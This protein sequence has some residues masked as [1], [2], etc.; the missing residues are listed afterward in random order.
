MLFMRKALVKTI[1]ILLCTNLSITPLLANSIYTFDQN[2]IMNSQ[3]QTN[4]V[5]EEIIQL[6]NEIF[7][8]IK[9]KDS[10]R[11]SKILTDDF[12]YRS[13]GNAEQKKAEFLKTVESI[14][15]T[16]LAIWSDDM[17]LNIY[18]DVA[19]MTGTQKAKVLLAKDKEVIVAT[20]FTD[21]FI[22]RQER[23]LLVLAHGVEL[24]SSSIDK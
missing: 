8:A 24:P 18:S 9:N 20:A 14:P 16:I 10:K 2:Q 6:E 22:K 5:E 13:P 15:I 21:I 4:R 17:K 1:T 7:A 3:N 12:V 19:V 23:W 11:L